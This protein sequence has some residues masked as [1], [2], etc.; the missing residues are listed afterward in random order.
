[1]YNS[2]LNN[3]VCLMLAMTGRFF[4]EAILSDYVILFLQLLLE[5]L[6]HLIFFYIFKYHYVVSTTIHDSVYY[7]HLPSGVILFHF[8]AEFCFFKSGI[9]CYDYIFYCIFTSNF[10]NFCFVCLPRKIRSV[11]FIQNVANFLLLF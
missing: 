11:P 3:S 2:L 4:I 6:L 5:Y 7:H 1:M 9:N 8:S 10:S